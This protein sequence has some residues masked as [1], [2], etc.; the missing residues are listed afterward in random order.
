MTLDLIAKYFPDLTVLQVLQFKQLESLYKTWNEQIN[1]ISR[2]DVDE[3]YLRHVLHSL[4]VAKIIQFKDYTRILDIGTGG[5][6]PGI[7]LAILFPNC[8]FVLVDSIGKK[9]KVVNEIVAALGLQNVNAINCRAEEVDGQF[10]FVVTRAVARIDKFIPW[11]KGKLKPEGFNNIKNGILFL[12]G[13]DL[14]QEIGESGKKVE[15][16]NL[17]T[18][19]TEEF[20]ETKVVVYTRVKK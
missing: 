11:V 7:P 17:S 10:D 14:A 4:G 6:F 15:I 12:K 1:V 3:L 13:G 9:I 8:R 19:F 20:F 2:K 16:Y 5:G 18:Y